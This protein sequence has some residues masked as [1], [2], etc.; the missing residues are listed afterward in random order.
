MSLI[1][2]YILAV[3]E[4]LPEN[5]RYD[6][7]EELRSNIEDM[8]PE[9]ATEGDIRGV[10][11]RL[12]NPK[13]L[14]QEYNPTKRYLIGPAIYDSYIAVLKIVLGIAVT[15]ITFIALL[16]IVLKGPSN[17]DNVN[18]Y[19]ELIV[20]LIE[21]AVTGAVQAVFWVTIV[22]AVMERI[23]INEGELPFVKKKWSVDDLPTAPVSEKSKISRAETVFSIFFT[24]LFTTLIFFKPQLI[25]IYVK[26]AG[27]TEVTPLF[28]SDRLQIYIVAILLLALVQLCVAGWK[29]VQGNWSVPLATANTIQN[30]A[31]SL[32]VIF[33]F[34]D[35]QLFNNSFFVKMGEILKIPATEFSDYWFWGTMVF[36]V[37][38]FAGLALWESISGFLKCRR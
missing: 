6:V 12:G 31:S 10:L 30:F 34:N 38:L 16:D 5:I 27:T 4:R 37:V 21:A 20:G 13:K 17:I 35:R 36:S 9:N 15:V 32:L 18:I 8:L 1:E 23:G 25:A 2:R 19:V 29:F 14:T 26:R 28:N 24:I 7:A 3:T 33:M 11:E 22:F